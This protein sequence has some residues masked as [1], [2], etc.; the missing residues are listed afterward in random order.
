MRAFLG[1]VGLAK[2]KGSFTC[3]DTGW[4]LFYVQIGDNVQME[5]FSTIYEVASKVVT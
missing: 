3:S 4:L 1:N 2:E 5:G